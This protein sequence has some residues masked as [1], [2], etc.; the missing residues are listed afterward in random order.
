MSDDIGVWKWQK[1]RINATVGSGAGAAKPNGTP[2]AL[3]ITVLSDTSLKLD[4]TRGSTNNDG[5][6]IYN[7][8]NVLVETVI[9]T[10]VTKTLTGLTADTLYGLYVKEYKGSKESVASS[11]VTASTWT[12]QY[13][14][15]YAAQYEKP[16]QALAN[17][18]NS[19]FVK[20]NV[21]SGLWAITDLMQVYLSHSNAG[22][23]SHINWI[24]P[25]ANTA[26]ESGSPT[27]TMG[28][29]YKGDDV[30]A[31][32][33]TNYNPYSQATHY[34]QNSAYI[35]AY[36]YE[37]GSSTSSKDGVFGS[38]NGFLSILDQKAF[39]RLRATV[40]SNNEYTNYTQ[41]SGASFVVATRKDANTICIYVNGVS[42]GDFTFSSNTIPNVILTALALNASNY[43]SGGISIVMAGSCP[44]QAQV[45]ALQNSWVAMKAWTDAF[46]LANNI[47]IDSTNIKI[48][49]TLHTI[50]EA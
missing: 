49:S 7:S 39:A 22:N 12:T 38:Q 10:A 19:L 23:T 36:I 46:F 32:I 29:G 26:S 30:A 31:K 40:N 1:N 6:H 5:T 3:V 35:A 17:A 2:S 20:P 13:A 16:V 15:V 14:A 18:W 43:Y 24:N 21:T 37:R 42:Q 9:G 34:T 45:T 41:L 8:S 47:R 11:T 50:D 4:W 28:K 25:A 44:T 27:Y 48:D 33:I